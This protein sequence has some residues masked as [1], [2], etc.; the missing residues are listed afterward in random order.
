LKFVQS[1]LVLSQDQRLS[2]SDALQHPW[3]QDDCPKIEVPRVDFGILESL[4]SFSQTQGFRRACLSLVAWCIP[5]DEAAVL[6]EQFHIMDLAGN[7]TISLSEFLHA[8][9]AVD[10]ADESEAVA[11]FQKLDTNNEGQITYRQFIAATWQGRV[12]LPDAAVHET[13]CRFDADASGEITTENLRFVV[14][15]K[16][17][18]F[19]AEELIREADEDGDGA[20]SYKDFQMFVQ[21]ECGMTS[22]SPVELPSCTQK[23]SVKLEERKEMVAVPGVPARVNDGCLPTSQVLAK[24]IGCI[25]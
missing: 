15:D 3:L 20:V 12:Q 18:G 9:Q 8:Y 1:L 11:V 7:G 16:F 19:K 13:F 14:G 24:V 10:F 25:A 17:A 22:L 6:L 5:V 4:R 23:T 21:R 2:A